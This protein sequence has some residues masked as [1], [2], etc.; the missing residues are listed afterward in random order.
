MTANIRIRL[1]A[2]SDGVQIER[3]WL[4]AQGVRIVGG[5]MFCGSARRRWAGRRIDPTLLR[6]NQP[7]AQTDDDEAA[8]DVHA[9]LLHSFHTPQSP[10]HSLVREL[11][12]RS[13]LVDLQLYTDQQ[14][15]I[16]V[17]FFN[18]RN[19]TETNQAHA[20]RLNLP[21]LWGR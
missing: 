15:R 18:S 5:L 10:R 8:F 17:H 16:H 3:P 13:T 6:S 9:R 20:D 12:Q 21:S 1:A 11:F 19:I 2:P 14:Y 4:P 7:Y